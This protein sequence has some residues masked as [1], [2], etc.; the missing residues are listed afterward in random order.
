MKDYPRL[1]S[2]RFSIAYILIRD[3]NDS[4]SHLEELVRLLNGTK[5]RVNILPYHTFSGD[6]YKPSPALRME[7]F[8]GKLNSSGISA[9]MRKTRGADISAACGLLAANK[10][11][12]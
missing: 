2:R 9:T 3:I 1:K 4:D 11:I 6:Q 7:Y 10:L 12:Q 8:T 5:I